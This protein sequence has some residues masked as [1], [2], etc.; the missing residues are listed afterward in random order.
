LR[1]LLAVIILLLSHG[2]GFDLFPKGT[3]N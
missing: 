1:M 3:L 2:I